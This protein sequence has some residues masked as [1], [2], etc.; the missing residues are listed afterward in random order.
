MG[1]I[2]ISIP[3]E[4]HG[5]PFSGMQEKNFYP[6]RKHRI[7]L[8]G[9]QIKFKMSS[10]PNNKNYFT[11]I[12]HLFT[13]FSY[14]ASEKHMNAMMHMRRP[15]VMSYYAPLTSKIVLLPQYFNTIVTLL[16]YIFIDVPNVNICLQHHGNAN[17][18]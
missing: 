4:N 15:F 9:M 16:V 2:R 17:Y 3:C 6:K 18:L 11:K 12:D 14:C 1:E 8:F 7:S 13:L 5:L 10:R